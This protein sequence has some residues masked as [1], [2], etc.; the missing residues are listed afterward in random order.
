M[1]TLLILRRFSTSASH[2]RPVATA[3]NL[4]HV[5]D[6][7]GFHKSLARAPPKDILKVHSEVGSLLP[8]KMNAQEFDERV[9]FPMVIPDS[10]SLMQSVTSYKISSSEVS[11]IVFFSSTSPEGPPPTAEDTEPSQDDFNKVADILIY[12]LSNLFVR[13]PDFR[14]YHP[15]IVF[16]NRITGE[17]VTGLLA[18]AK[19]MHFLRIYGNAR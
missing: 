12:D 15:N 16:E 14:I 10:C 5:A 6:D 4:D 19:K 1:S 2:F 13:T 3:I 9:V 8:K 17:T 18:Y 7:G 11:N